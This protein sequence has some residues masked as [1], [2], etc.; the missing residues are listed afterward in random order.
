MDSEIDRRGV[1][2]A[3]KTAE[4]WVPLSMTISAPARTRA[5]RPA[6]SRAASSSEMWITWSAMPRLYRHGFA[7]VSGLY[8]R[9]AVHPSVVAQLMELPPPRHRHGRGLAFVVL[10]IDD[11]VALGG[12]AGAFGA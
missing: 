1:S 5:M 6:K 8:G 11:H 4:G 2:A 9:L 3:R 12:L 7:G 10:G